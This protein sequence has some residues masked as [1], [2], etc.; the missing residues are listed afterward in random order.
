MRQCC[1]AVE[2]AIDHAFGT[3]LLTF[4]ERIEGIPVFSLEQVTQLQIALIV[5]DVDFRI[6][7]INYRIQLRADRNIKMSAIANQSKEGKC[8][9]KT[10]RL[11]HVLT[12]RLCQGKNCKSNQADQGDFDKGR[13]HVN[14]GAQESTRNPNRETFQ[15]L[16]GLSH[17]KQHEDCGNGKHCIQMS[18]NTQEGDVADKDQDAIAGIFVAMLVPH[19]AQVGHQHED[20]H[21]NAVNFG[22]HSIEPEG[23]GE[24]QEEASNESGSTKNDGASL[25]V[26]LVGETFHKAF[27][28]FLC[29]IKN[30]S[31]EFPGEQGGHVDRSSG[32]KHR[33]IVHALCDFFHEG[34]QHDHS[35]SKEYEEGSSRRMRNTQGICTGYEFTT[36][37]KGHRGSHGQAINNQRNKTCNAGKNMLV[38]FVVKHYLDSLEGGMTMPFFSMKPVR[39]PFTKASEES[40]LYFAA[41]WTASEIA[42]FM[43]TSGM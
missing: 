23:I 43:G 25:A 27:A 15:D 12:E 13:H 11:V 22:F 21:C 19:Q 26:N 41:I 14:H 33:D 30:E 34:K 24:S 42:T 3:I 40:V 1:T 4:N 7:F 6:V 5:T 9:G 17:Q 20:Q 39:I 10:N 37:P 29:G 18:A 32:T 2:S 16:L 31:Q 8:Q 28:L 36:V 35:T 38:L